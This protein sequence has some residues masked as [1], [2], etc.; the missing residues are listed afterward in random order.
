MPK[1]LLR[2]LIIKGALVVIIVLIVLW[3]AGII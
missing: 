1:W 3:Y 2:A